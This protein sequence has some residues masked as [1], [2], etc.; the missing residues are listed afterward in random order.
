MSQ[1]IVNCHAVA[2]NCHR[3]V[4][5]ALNVFSQSPENRIV[6]V[7]IDSLTSWGEFTKGDT[8]YAEK[9]TSTLFVALLNYLIFLVLD[10]A[11]RCHCKDCSLVTGIP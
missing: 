10:D 2:P 4:G 5:K 6:K 3:V 7:K 1:G 9:K 11:G 8:V